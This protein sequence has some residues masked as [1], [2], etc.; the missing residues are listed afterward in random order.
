MARTVSSRTA[1]ATFAIATFA[2]AVLGLTGCGREQ[3]ASGANPPPPGDQQIGGAPPASASPSA[4]PPA[5][6]GGGGGGG[7]GNQGPTYPKDARAYT[8]EFLRAWGARN[9]SRLGQLGDDAAVQQVRDSVSTGGAPNNQWTYIRCGPAEQMPDHTAC[10]FRN[11]HGDESTVKL[12]TAKLGSPKAVTEAPLDRT[13]YDSSPGDYVSDMLRAHGAGNRQ[14]VLRLS[15]STV[16]GKL[17][18]DMSGGSVAIVTPIDG[19]YSAVKLE[20]AGSDI[21]KSYEF[22]VLSQPGGKPN[23]VREVINNGC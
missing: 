7:G 10:T 2:I 19:M 15:T 11:A 13:A 17:T 12:L 16:R 21:G 22:K 4:T 14:R 5:G 18:C 23:A 3:P 6:G 8:Q 20:G 1:I 9:F